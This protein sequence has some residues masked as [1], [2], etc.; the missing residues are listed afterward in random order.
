MV[1]F[2]SFSSITLLVVLL[3]TPSFANQ[4][5]YQENISQ[6]D[7]KAICSSTIVP[8]Y[9]FQVFK[10]DPKLVSADLKGVANILL[11]KEQGNLQQTANVIKELV[12][13]ASPKPPPGGG[14]SL[15]ERYS[16]CSETYGDG[17]ESVKQAKGYIS[18][19]DYFSAQTQVSGLLDDIGTCDDDLNKPISDASQLPKLN[20]DNISL[21]RVILAVIAKLRG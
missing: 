14:P 7:I 13:Q 10:S 6:G 21:S 2:C 18:S 12:K 4:N 15:K 11:D 3:I 19:G 8:D 1:S 16:E 20:Q 5:G 9:C 17:L